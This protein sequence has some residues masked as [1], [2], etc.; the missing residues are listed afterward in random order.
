MKELKIITP[1]NFR[2]KAGDGLKTRKHEISD[3]VPALQAT[4]GTTQMSYVLEK[5]MEEVNYCKGL[6]V[7]GFDNCFPLQLAEEDVAMTVLANATSTANCII[8]GHL[9]SGTGRH[10]SNTVYDT[11]G[12]CPALTT[13]EGGGTQQ[14]KILEEVR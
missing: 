1:N 12:I 7:W 11:K 3:I 2:H 9:E 10:Q 14:V 8:L 13:I 4:P 5:D 6:R